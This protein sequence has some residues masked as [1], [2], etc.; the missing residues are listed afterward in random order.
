[1]SDMLDGLSLFLKNIFSIE[2]DQRSYVN[3][4]P[5]HHVLISIQVI[6]IYTSQQFD[7]IVITY[8]NMHNTDPGSTKTQFIACVL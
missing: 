8:T 1:M 3:S 6:L 5:A 7:E 2:C 4:S